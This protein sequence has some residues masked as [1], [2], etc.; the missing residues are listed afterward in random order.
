M[1]LLFDQNRS[2]RLVGDLADI[3]PQ[4]THVYQ[5]ALDRAPDL[6]VWNFVR[7]QGYVIVS[8]DSDFSDLSTCSVFSQSNLDTPW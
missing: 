8:Q 5:I 4:S 1:K 6:D 7:D 2:P 3:Y